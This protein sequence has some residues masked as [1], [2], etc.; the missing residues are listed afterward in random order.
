MPDLAVSYHD[1]QLRV[2]VAGP[3]DQ[4]AANTASLYVNNIRRAHEANAKQPCRLIVSSTL[5]TDYEWHEFI[6]ATV[7]IVNQVAT[8]RLHANNT[9][10]GDIS[11]RLNTA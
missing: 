2:E 7:D 1:N 9:L 6:E 4:Q 3:S 5:Q 10:I 11:L 8:I